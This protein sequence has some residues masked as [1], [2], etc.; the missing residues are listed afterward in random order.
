MIEDAGNVLVVVSD[1]DFLEVSVLRSESDG[2]STI[3]YCPPPTLSGR[4]V[5][6]P[7]GRDNKGG[8]GGIGYNFLKINADV[9]P[10]L[11]GAVQEKNPVFHLLCYFFA[12]Y[13]ELQDETKP[14]SWWSQ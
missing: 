4:G 1:D 8:G 6:D 2:Q 9:C 14:A 3:P 12:I 7:G 11:A 13:C 10:A 5:R